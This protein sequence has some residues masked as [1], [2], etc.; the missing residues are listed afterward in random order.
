MKVNFV[1][2]KAQYQTIKPEVDAAIAEV[3]ANTAFVNSR[4]LPSTLEPISASVW[5]TVPML[6]SWP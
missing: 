3:I 6:C 4:I 1:D 2:L 5:A